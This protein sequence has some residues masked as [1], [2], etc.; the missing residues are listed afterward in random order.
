MRVRQRERERE[1]ERETETVG[2]SETNEDFLHKN[3]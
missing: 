2:L 1:R 3:W